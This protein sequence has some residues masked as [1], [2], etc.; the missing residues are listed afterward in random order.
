MTAAH[1]GAVGVVALGSMLLGACGGDDDA[2]FAGPLIGEIAPAIDAV[3]EE[4]GGPQQFFE[5]FA[6]LNKVSV[7]VAMDDATRAVLY[8]WASD[9]LT[10]VESRPAEGETFVAADLDI[11]ADDILDQVLDDLGD[12]VTKFSV[13]GGEGD[14]VQYSALVESDRGGILEV[15]VDGDGKILESGPL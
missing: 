14:I 5:V 15:V 9:E 13:I 3:E 4:L 11:D 7:W 1:Q 6:D 8:V 12:N 10:E 2:G